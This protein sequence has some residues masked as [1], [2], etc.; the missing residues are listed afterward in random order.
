MDIG[1]ITRVITTDDIVITV[2]VGGGEGGAAGW[3]A[4]GYGARGGSGG[5]EGREKK[6]RREKGGWY[7]GGVWEAVASG[8]WSGGWPAVAGGRRR[9]KG[10]RV[11]GEGLRD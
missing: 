7:G 1:C 9:E 8:W 2:G 6:G 10:K 5:E 11:R 3:P 4:V